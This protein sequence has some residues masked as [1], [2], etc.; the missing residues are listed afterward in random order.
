INQIANQTNLL[1]LNASII[2]VQAG[3]Y[4]K[5]FG[6]VANEIKKLSEETQV[7]TKEIE[8]LIDGLQIEV[9]KVVKSMSMGEKGIDT[10]VTLALKAGNVL[11]KILESSKRSAEMVD[12]IVKATQEQARGTLAATHAVERIDGMVQNIVRATQEQTEGAKFVSYRMENMKALTEGVKKATVEQARGSRQIANSTVILNDMINQ[13]HRA[14]QGQG[15]ESERLMENLEKIVAVVEA[16]VVAI[17]RMEEV[18]KVLSAQVNT[19]KEEVGRFT[20]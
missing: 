11:T 6:V 8:D 16:N 13:I 4:G 20:L 3:E 14:V 7:S 2:A 17:K 15:V 1:A 12:G 18:A 10:S 5:G 19:L 9:E